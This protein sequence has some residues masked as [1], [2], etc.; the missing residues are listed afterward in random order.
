MELHGDLFGGAVSYAAGIFNGASGLQR[1]HDNTDFD[2]TRRLTD[3]FFVQPW[4]KS[5]V[6]AL[7]G[8]GLWRG[9]QL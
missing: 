9:R 7:A 2:K 3:V 6:E 1:H 8:S 4:K 5:G